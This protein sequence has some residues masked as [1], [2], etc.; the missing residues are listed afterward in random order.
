M[1]VA[2]GPDEHLIGDGSVG[3]VEKRRRMMAV[4]LGGSPAVSI[5]HVQIR[6]SIWYISDKRI[7]KIQEYPRS[8]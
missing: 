8:Y 3:I 1:K 7:R 2:A 6:Y 5:E 4:F